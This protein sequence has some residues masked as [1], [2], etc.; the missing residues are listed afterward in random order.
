M[1]QAKKNSKEPNQLG[2]ELD[3]VKRIQ[4]TQIL[5]DPEAPGDIM[6]L[7]LRKDIAAK[8]ELSQDEMTAANMKND[9]A[10]LRWDKDKDSSKTIIF[11]ELELGQ[12][13]GRLQ[14]LNAQKKLT[15]HLI[16]LYDTFI[17]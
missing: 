15:M 13:K 3:I 11:T 9:G 2:H 17:Q 1:S 10:I 12:I 4:L 6:T 5:N 14:E 8:T 7:K 16:D